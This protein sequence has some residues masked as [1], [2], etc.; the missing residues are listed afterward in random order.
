DTD[1]R[2]AFSWAA[3]ESHV[4]VANILVDAG[5]DIDTRDGR[6][7]SPISWA[8]QNGHLD[9]VELLLN[10]RVDAD[11]RNKDDRTPPSWAAEYGKEAVVELPINI[12]MV[13]VYS[14]DKNGR[15]PLSLSAAD[16]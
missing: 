12:G 4:V 13:D 7:R 10:N 15:T 5:V 2:T 8:A 14:T 1:G 16:G 3:G 11:S 9:I 6:S